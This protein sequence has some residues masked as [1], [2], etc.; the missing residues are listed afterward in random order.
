MRVSFAA[1]VVVDHDF[2]KVRFGGQLVVAARRPENRIEGVDVLDVKPNVQRL[3]HAFNRSPHL[4]Q[5]L[6]FRLVE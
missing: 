4:R 5:D 2:E 1:T 3:S 6:M